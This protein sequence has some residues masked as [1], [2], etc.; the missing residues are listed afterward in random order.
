MARRRRKSMEATV[1]EIASEGETGFYTT[2]ADFCRDNASTPAVC[3]RARQLKKGASFSGGGGAAPRFIVTSH[4][5][6]TREQRRANFGIMADSRPGRKRHGREVIDFGGSMA[7]DER[8]TYF[9]ERQPRYGGVTHPDP[10]V[11]RIQ[12]S[13]YRSGGKQIGYYAVGA[14]YAKRRAA[15]ARK[16]R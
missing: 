10:L 1:L 6:T 3:R 2:L 15:A 14:D 4:G 16:R 5:V 9:P 7:S 12:H 11:A 8:T 13:R